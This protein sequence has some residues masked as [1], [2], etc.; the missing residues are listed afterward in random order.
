MPPSVGGRDGLPPSQGRS[1]TM[2]KL[3]LRARIQ[4]CG[5]GIYEAGS[6]D[7]CYVR[8]FVTDSGYVLPVNHRVIGEE[9]LMEVYTQGVIDGRGGSPL[10]DDAGYAAQQVAEADQARAELRRMDAEDNASFMAT[11]EGDK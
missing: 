3:E 1:E 11:D 7:R 8:L 4:R 5:C 9:D 10:P 2:D 6:D